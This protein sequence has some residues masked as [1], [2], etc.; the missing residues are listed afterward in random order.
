MNFENFEIQ[1]LGR[2]GI[3]SG[4]VKRIRPLTTP[5]QKLGSKEKEKFTQ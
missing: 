2:S 4:W 3:R 5:Q 1:I